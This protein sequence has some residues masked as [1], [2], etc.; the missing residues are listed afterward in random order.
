MPK[1]TVY[2]IF[3]YFIAAVWVA[4]GL[5]AKVLN[6]VPRHGEIVGRILGGEYARIF[7]ILIGSAEC[8]MALWI[9]AGL[10][11]RFN[12]VTQM[13]VIATMNIM[14]FIL[15]PDILLWGRLNAL[16]AFLFILFIGYNEFTLRPK[17]SIS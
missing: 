9:I 15:V 8:I 10:W 14:E 4:N 16:F 17:T 7:T 5:F 6:L 13:T 1:R 12:A 2:L 3:N 11:R